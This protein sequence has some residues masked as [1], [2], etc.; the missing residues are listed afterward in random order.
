MGR[1][2]KRPSCIG[3]IRRHAEIVS[4]PYDK[5]SLSLLRRAVIGGVQQ[6]KRNIISEA[7]AAP[8]G[9]MPMQAAQMIGPDFIGCARDLG[10]FQACY[11][12]REIIRECWAGQSLDVFDDERPR[13]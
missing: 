11:H 1:F 10:E 4:K 12:V 3:L 2:R 8:G 9:L 7:A 6:T 13:A 5:H